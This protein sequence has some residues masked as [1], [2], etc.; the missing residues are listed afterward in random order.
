MPL[1]VGLMDRS[2]ARQSLDYPLTSDGVGSAEDGYSSLQELADKRTAGGNMLDS[3]ANMANSI[4]GAGKVE[5]TL[6]IVFAI[7]LHL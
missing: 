7:D 4:L 6:P 5:R 2:A 3:I 1:L